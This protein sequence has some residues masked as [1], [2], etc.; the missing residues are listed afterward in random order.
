MDR[1]IVFPLLYDDKLFV[2]TGYDSA[3]VPLDKSAP[4]I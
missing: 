2:W 1:L 4:S 3:P